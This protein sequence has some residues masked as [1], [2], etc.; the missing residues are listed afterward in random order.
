MD[1]PLVSRN[2]P[3]GVP[4]Q[5]GRPAIAAAAASG[6]MSEKKQNRDYTPLRLADDES[7]AGSAF[8]EGG[9][10]PP[11]PRLPGSIRRLSKMQEFFLLT[12]ANLGPGCLA[13]PWAFSRLGVVRTVLLT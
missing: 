4:P 12:R 1:E 7:A 3:H 5:G 11:P 6:S 9:Y 2:E 13:L 8:S 10:S